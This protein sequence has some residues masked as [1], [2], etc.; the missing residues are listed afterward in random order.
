MIAF[1]SGYYSPEEYEI[2]IKMSYLGAWIIGGRPLSEYLVIEY[3][4]IIKELFILK[5]KKL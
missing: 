1:L 5:I 4:K 3:M 2:L